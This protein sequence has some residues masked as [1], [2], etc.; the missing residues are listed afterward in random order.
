MVF[1]GSRSFRH[2]EDSLPLLYKGI[3]GGRMSSV[4]LLKVIEKL[5]TVVSI[6]ALHGVFGSL[7][8]S[9]FIIYFFSSLK[10]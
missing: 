9:L 3:F 8:L 1:L 2:Y 5:I 6:L 7:A 10:L 4:H